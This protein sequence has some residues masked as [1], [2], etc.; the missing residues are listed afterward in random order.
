MPC[1]ENMISIWFFRASD[2][3]SICHTGTWSQR[4]LHL[5]DRGGTD[6]SAAAGHAPQALDGAVDLCQ[7][8]HDHRLKLA[9]ALIVAL[10]AR[11]MKT[12]G[13]GQAV[14]VR[15]KIAPGAARAC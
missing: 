2:A 15:H 5:S 12:Q 1:P 10:D 8:R 13:L 14:I 7:E 11:H 9:D 4:G 6:Q 3:R